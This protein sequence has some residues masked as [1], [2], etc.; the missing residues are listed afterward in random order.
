MNMSRSR[1]LIVL[2]SYAYL[3]QEWCCANFRCDSLPVPP[4]DV[5]VAVT[6]P[7]LRPQAGPPAPAGAVSASRHPHRAGGSVQTH[8][9]R[10]Q[11]ADW[12]APA[13]ADCAHVEAQLRGETSEEMEAPFYL[14]GEED[15]CIFLVSLLFRFLLLSSGRS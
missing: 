4:H 3:E 14:S 12:R 9:A 1:R 2:L 15:C 11:A 6:P 5:S 10:H 13:P 8:E 7:C